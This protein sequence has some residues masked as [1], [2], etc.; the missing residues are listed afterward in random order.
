MEVRAAHRGK[1]ITSFGEDN[2]DKNGSTG[3]NIQCAII[4]SLCSAKDRNNDD[5]KESNLSETK[6][7]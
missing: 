7:P 4:N 3:L 5:A 2:S 6:G 1:I